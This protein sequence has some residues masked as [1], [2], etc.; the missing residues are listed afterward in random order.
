MERK[1][2]AW[3]KPLHMPLQLGPGMLKD[4][5]LLVATCYIPYLLS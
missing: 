5:E 1:L 2:Y 4:G 3:F